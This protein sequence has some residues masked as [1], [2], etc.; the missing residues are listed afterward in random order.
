MTRWIKVAGPGEFRGEGVWQTIE[1][2]GCSLEDWEWNQ[3]TGYL[4][5]WVGDEPPQE[6]NQDEQRPE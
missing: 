6:R 4:P 2:A 3:R 5:T 1:E